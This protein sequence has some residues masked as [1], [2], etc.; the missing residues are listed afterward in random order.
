MDSAILLLNNWGLMIKN[1]SDMGIYTCFIRARSNIKSCADYYW[2]RKKE[3]SLFID[4]AFLI[5]KRSC[6]TVK[7]SRA[8][9]PGC[10]CSKAGQCYPSDKLLPSGQELGKTTTVRYP[11]DRDLSGVES[12]FQLL[13][14]LGLVFK[15]R[16][17]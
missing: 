2:E 14:N 7:K 4:L 8:Q 6:I 3:R 17:G 5:H 15:H 1:L 13:N 16:L 10:S 12:T 9:E 11:L